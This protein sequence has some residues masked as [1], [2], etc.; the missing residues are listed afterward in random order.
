MHPQW[1]RQIRDDCAAAGVPFLFKQWGAWALSSEAEAGSNPHAGWLSPQG[2]HQVA[3]TGD[4]Y[5]ENGAAFLVNVGKKAAGRVL[6]GC[7]HD[8]MPRGAE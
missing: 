4:L 6:D 5:P 7:T 2:H 8:A 3:R 1:A